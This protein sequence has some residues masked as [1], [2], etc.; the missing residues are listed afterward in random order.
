MQAQLQHSDGVRAERAVVI[1]LLR[2]DHGQQWTSEELREALPDI[3]P[4][5]IAGALGR[6]EAEGVAYHSARY[7]WAT[8]P[9]RRLDA[10]GL[11]AI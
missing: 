10:L 9:V 7:Y 5:S 6:L 4:P 11:I 3:D 8:G 1:Q 2:E